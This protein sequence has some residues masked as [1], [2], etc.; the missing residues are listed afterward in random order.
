LKNTPGFPEYSG[1]GMKAAWRPL[2]HFP[3]KKTKMDFQVQ[4]NE[5]KTCN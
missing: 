5:E 4:K 2:I 1:K 3:E